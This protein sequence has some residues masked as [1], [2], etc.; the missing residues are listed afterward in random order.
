M[1]QMHADGENGS[2]EFTICVNLRHLRAEVFSYSLTQNEQEAK[3]DRGTVAPT[4]CDICPALHGGAMMAVS[5]LLIKDDNTTN[6][7][8][9]VANNF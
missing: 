6:P 9:L 7:I 5:R 8:K 4:I 1:T 3:E 2:S